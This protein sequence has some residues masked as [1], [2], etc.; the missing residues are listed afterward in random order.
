LIATLLADLVRRNL[1]QATIS[2]FSFRA[3]SALFDTSPFFVCG[4]PD[5]DGRTVALWARDSEGALAVEATATLS[6]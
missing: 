3:I 2:S 4:R 6:P 1:P 5:S